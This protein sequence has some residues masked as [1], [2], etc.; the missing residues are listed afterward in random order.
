MQH[1]ELATATGHGRLAGKVAIV[2]GAG[3][4]G[5]D[6]SNGSAA[7]IVYAR[8]GARVLCVDRDAA[9]AQQVVERIRDA[10]GEAQPFK[11]DVS[12][13]E[14]LAAMT[15]DCI[16]KYGRIDVLHNNVGIEIVAELEDIRE[17]DWDRVFDINLKGVMLACQQ[18][19]PHMVKQRGGSIINISSIASRKW[20]PMPFLAYNTSKA[21]LN[22]MT[23]VLARRYAADQV[24]ANVVV[25]GL[26]DT[27]HAAHLT[28]GDPAAVQAARDARNQRCPM[29]R[30][31]T[32]W[33]V[34]YASL[35][36]AGNESRY[37][38]GTEIAVD[39]GLYL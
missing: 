21:G 8:E 15:A 7:A 20:S 2:V 11:A 12:S 16:S 9:A 38:T 1:S 13:K 17:E 36:L 26:I 14:Q 18:V 24:R 19:I 22:H 32:A 4:S 37:V 28:V 29:G 27:P 39:G 35:F 25:P 5:P 34:A 31:G 23:R 33:D 3:S 10:G 30:Q 6:V